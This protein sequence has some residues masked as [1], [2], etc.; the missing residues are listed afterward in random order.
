MSVERF[1]SNA[2]SSLSLL[3]CAFAT[4]YELTRYVGSKDNEELN[5]PRRRGREGDG[6]LGMGGTKND[7]L[8]GVDIARRSAYG[9][10]GEIAKCS[11]MMGFCSDRGRARK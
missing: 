5:E 6:K 7:G 2:M 1:G 10:L 8:G 3:C 11:S 9:S 4:M